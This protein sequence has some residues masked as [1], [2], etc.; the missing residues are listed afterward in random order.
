MI[1][2][3]SYIFIFLVLYKITDPNVENIFNFSDRYFMSIV[4]NYTH[5]YLANKWSYEINKMD[6]LDL[7]YN[8]LEKINYIVNDYNDTKVCR[9]TLFL[10]GRKHRIAT[11]YPLNN[12]LKK[13]FNIYKSLEYHNLKFQLIATKLVD[14]MPS[15]HIVYKISIVKKG[16]EEG[17]L[18]SG[19]E[20]NTAFV[21][22][23]ISKSCTASIL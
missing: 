16:D 22:N 3:I 12:I 4:P 10:E 15:T 23:L 7:S 5:R 2:F 13:Y 6:K 8:F 21:L 9:N 19:I 18:V 14:Q 20:K 11:V 17:I 1:K